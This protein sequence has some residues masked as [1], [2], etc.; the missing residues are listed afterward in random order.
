MLTMQQVSVP[1]MGGA[2]KEVSTAELGGV[3]QVD[4]PGMGSGLQDGCFLE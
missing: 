2:Q 1:G 3:Q 4:V